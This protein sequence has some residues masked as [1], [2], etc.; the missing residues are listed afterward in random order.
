[1]CRKAQDKIPIRAVP[2]KDAMQKVKMQ[3]FI[4]KE[5]ETEIKCVFFFF[6]AN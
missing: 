6:F 4:M 5:D 1:M 2:Q 3:L